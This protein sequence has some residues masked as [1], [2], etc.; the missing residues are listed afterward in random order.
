MILIQVWNILLKLQCCNWIKKKFGFVL[1]NGKELQNAC[2]NSGHERFISGQHSLQMW[3]APAEIADNHHDTNAAGQSLTKTTECEECI[4]ISTSSNREIITSQRW[5]R[6]NDNTPTTTITSN[7]HNLSGD[8]LSLTLSLPSEHNED[9]RL[10]RKRDS[11]FWLRVKCFIPSF[12]EQNM[13]RHTIFARSKWIF[14]KLGRNLE[15]WKP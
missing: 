9:H 11:S 1:E 5:M 2:P 15:S 7:T 8:E 3:F 14:L 12:R 4:I 6:L 13:Q 10:Y